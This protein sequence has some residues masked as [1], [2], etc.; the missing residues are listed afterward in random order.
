LC[1]A[2]LENE[3]RAGEMTNRGWCTTVLVEALLSRGRDKDID[4]AQTAIDD[5]AATPVEPGY[6]YHELP[7]LRLTAIVAKA[8]GDEE[9]YR[10]F[11]DRYRARAESS[12]F[13]GH[14]TLAHAMI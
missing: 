1:R 5:L 11:R 3:I 14:I 13:E 9:R 10:D 6:L 4:E 8:R 2:V 12:G 7:V